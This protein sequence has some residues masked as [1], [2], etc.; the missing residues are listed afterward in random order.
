MP[1]KKHQSTRQKV[2][3]E[4]AG[5]ISDQSIHKM[6]RNE[7]IIIAGFIGG[8]ILLLVLSIFMLSKKGVTNISVDNT[9]KQPP[10]IKK[11]IVTT[12]YPTIPPITDFTMQVNE[13]RFYPDKVN[14]T[15]GHTVTI[16][17]IG[18]DTTDVELIDDNS[19]LNFGIISQGD[20]KGIKYDNERIIR[21]S[22]KSG[23]DK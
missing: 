22:G 5:F 1:R 13:H 14:I 19:K 21:K 18:Q 12:P 20:Q 4:E 7:K 2:A 11:G 16:I 3:N 8:T 9:T 6:N 10:I 17:N 15:R 23:K